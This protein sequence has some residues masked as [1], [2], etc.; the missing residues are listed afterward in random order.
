L[1]CDADDPLLE[2]NERSASPAN[3]NLRDRLL[4]DSPNPVINAV[5]APF[6]C[7]FAL[8]W[9]MALPIALG[10]AWLLIALALNVLGINFGDGGND[11]PSPDTC[12]GS[13]GPYYC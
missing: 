10:I 5:K 1:D 4:D 2:A 12:Y 7:L 11:S 6:G 8:A 13:H 9:Y 3:R